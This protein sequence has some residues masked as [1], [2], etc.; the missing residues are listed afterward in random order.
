MTG[1]SSSSSGSS[2]QSHDTQEVMEFKLPTAPRLVIYYKMRDRWMYLITPMEDSLSI[3]P[4]RCCGNNMRRLFSGSNEN[5]CKR[6][7]LEQNKGTIDTLLFGPGRD[8]PGWALDVLQANVKRAKKH[9]E[10]VSF[11]Y[12]TIEFSS[13]LGRFSPGFQHGLAGG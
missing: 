6:T 7:V 4:K 1:F 13:N 11:K 12:I 2:S 8:E 10:K 3:M 5:C 9:G